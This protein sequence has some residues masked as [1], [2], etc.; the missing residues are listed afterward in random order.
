M[1]LKRAYGW[2]ASLQ[3]KSE[4]HG[5]HYIF[6]EEKNYGSTTQHDSAEL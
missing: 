3:N 4:W 1:N 2:Q 6:K 5:S